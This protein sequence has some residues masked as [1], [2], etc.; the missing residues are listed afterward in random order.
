MGVVCPGHRY[1]P[2][3]RR[4]NQGPSRRRRVD[5]E[6]LARLQRE[7]EVLASLNHANGAVHG[8]EKSGGV[9]AIIMELVEGPTLEER[10]ARDPVPADEAL[11]IARQIADA[12]DAAHAQ[13]IVPAISSPR[14]SSFDRPVL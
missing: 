9:S 6:R 3:A 7:A 5:P 14:T 13:S 11:A 12:L 1:E 2:Q 4:R 8:L 10:M